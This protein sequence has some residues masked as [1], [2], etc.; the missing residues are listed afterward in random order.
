MRKTS[1]YLTEEQAARLK[2][3]AAA[4]GRPEAEILREAIER[5]PEPERRRKI[6]CYAVADGP[7]DAIE[8]LS[9]EA[10]LEGFGEDDLGQWR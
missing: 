3:L 9:E 5:Y 6:L 10:L 2:R 7:G 4:E 1:V 8:H